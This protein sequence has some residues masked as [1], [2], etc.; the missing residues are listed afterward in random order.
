MT[1]FYL[2]SILEIE[3]DLSMTDYRG[4]FPRCGGGDW[5]TEMFYLEVYDVVTSH[6]PPS[7]LTAVAR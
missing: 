5:C 2:K 6:T 4:R 1:G 3:W 7:L